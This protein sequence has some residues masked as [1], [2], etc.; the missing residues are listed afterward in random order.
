MSGNEF[1]TILKLLPSL[2]GPLAKYLQRDFNIF[3]AISDTYYKENLHSDILALILD[4]H[5]EKIGNITYLK[6]FLEDTDGLFHT[7]FKPYFQDE[8]SVEVCREAG[9]TDILVH[10]GQYGI[11]IEN[12]INKAPDMPNQLCRYLNWAEQVKKLEVLQIFYIP[13]EKD[14]R[15]PIQNYDCGNKDYAFCEKCKHRQIPD[16]IRKRLNEITKVLNLEPLAEILEKCALKA[17]SIAYKADYYR[18]AK[19]FLEHYAKLISKVRGNMA[20]NKVSFLKEIFNEIKSKNISNGEMN[21]IAGIAETW[22]SRETTLRQTLA[23]KLCNSKG[24]SKLEFTQGRFVYRKQIDKVRAI[25]Y[26]PEW[27]TFGL[28]F[29]SEPDNKGIEDAKKVLN[30]AI[31]NAEVGEEY[32]FQGKGGARCDKNKNGEF[33][34]RTVDNKPC[35]WVHLNFIFANIRIQNIQIKN[36]DNPFD[37]I[38]DNAVKCFTELEK[39]F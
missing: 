21:D 1:D 7:D 25:D 4:P 13:F 38:L 28:A 16:D 9:D 33:N 27:G 12:K 10:N 17:D 39:L 29:T 3:T 35:Y 20:D 31:R 36:E 22:G 32:F 24:Y 6:T 8:N 26:Y 15:P 23:D 11:I 2:Q 19:V 34:K 30:E 18:T 14:K 5:T 37:T